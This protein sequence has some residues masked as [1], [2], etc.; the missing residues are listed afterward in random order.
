[1]DGSA[2]SSNENSSS[3][4]ARHRLDYLA[5]AVVYNPKIFTFLKSSRNKFIHPYTRP[6]SI[7]NSNL[8]S[9]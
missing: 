8:R 4:I 9:I 3:A 6:S 5:G 2:V 1:M 7:K